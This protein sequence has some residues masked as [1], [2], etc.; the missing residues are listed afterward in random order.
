MPSP[1]S[2]TFVSVVAPIRNQALW[3][4]PF[5]SELAAV[6]HVSYDNYEILLVDDGSDDAT[7]SHLRALATEMDC[8]R[9]LLLSRPFGREAALLAGMESAIG[10]YVVVMLPECDPPALLPTMLEQCRRGTGLVI[11]MEQEPPPRS[12]A[13]HAASRFFHWYCHRWLRLD[14]HRGSSFLRI[15]SRS[16]L[17]GVLQIKDRVRT[18]RYLTSI[19]GLKA[20]LFPYAPV[21]RAGKPASRSFRHDF[22]DG[23]NIILASS[24]YPLRLA[25]LLGLFAGAINL[26]YLGYVV[27]IYLFKSHVTEGWTTLSMQQG[28]MFFL[29][30][31]ILTVLSEYVGLILAE[32]QDRPAYFV[33]GEIH[34]N[35]GLRDP[36]RHNV[37]TE[38]H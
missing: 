35:R 8:L 12:L 20:E 32:S 2:D 5:V 34:S 24:R 38:S 17:N 30:F 21:W 31:L 4:T 27:A 14:L 26:L 7:P 23:I 1:H 3:I 37:V 22:T 28:V 16:A 10:D 11:G 33:A 25:T 15:F 6:L 36:N 19:V 18:L 13:A 29:L 9:V